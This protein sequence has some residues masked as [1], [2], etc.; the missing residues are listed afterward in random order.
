M[1]CLQRTW[2]EGPWNGLICAAIAIRYAEVEA[3][4]P[5]KTNLLT[6]AFAVESNGEVGDRLPMSS[7]GSVKI[8]FV[9]RVGAGSLI[10]GVRKTSK[11]L[12][13]ESDTEWETWEEIIC[14]GP[15]SRQTET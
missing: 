1:E 8:K 4:R 11:H 6:L 2:I 15:R 14:F 12:G 10:E 13:D 9:R 7:S 5:G 3:E